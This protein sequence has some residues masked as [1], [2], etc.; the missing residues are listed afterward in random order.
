MYART[1]I[2]INYYNLLFLRLINLLLEKEKKT[3]SDEWLY[4]FLWKKDTA[5]LPTA[6]G[7]ENSWRR[8]RNYVG[9]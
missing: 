6:D 7:A 1:L 8:S 9:T 2:Y 4:H 3:K 5:H